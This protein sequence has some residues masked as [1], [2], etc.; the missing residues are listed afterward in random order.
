MW[1]LKKKKDTNGL[2]YKTKTDSQASKRNFW[3]PKGMDR[4]GD[5]LGVRD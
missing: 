3:L 4:Q 1:N 2:I 5:K